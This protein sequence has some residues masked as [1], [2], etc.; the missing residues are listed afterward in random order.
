MAV[1]LD[2]LFESIMALDVVSRNG[3]SVFGLRF[4][5]LLSVSDFESEPSGVAL[6]VVLFVRF[7][8]VFVVVFVFAFP[9]PLVLPLLLSF[10]ST[11]ISTFVDD[12]FWV[13]DELLLPP[14]DWLSSLDVVG[15]A[16]LS[17]GSTSLS[18]TV[19][20]NTFGQKTEEEEK[21]KQKK[22]K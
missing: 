19:N 15:F 10:G 1:S 12:D 21:N 4:V 14:L 11:F 13:F 17:D 9:L 18:S 3:N 8:F 7:V 20:G 6:L 5:E 16:S 2:L 22:S